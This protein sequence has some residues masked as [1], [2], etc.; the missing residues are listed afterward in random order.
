[1]KFYIAAYIREKRRVNEIQRK[2]KRLGHE[3][4]VDWTKDDAPKLKSRYRLS[5]S[6]KAIAIRDMKGVLDCDVFVLLSD[7]AHGRAKYVELGAAIASFMKNGRPL[8]YILGKKNIQSVFYYHPAVKRV[9]SLEE[10]ICDVA[11]YDSVYAPKT[12]GQ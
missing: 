6:T 9:S 11:G 5:E 7:P 3:I 4:T 8:V 10:V 2:L 12:E 1:M